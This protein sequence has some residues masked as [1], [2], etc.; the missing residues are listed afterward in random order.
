MLCCV[1]CACWMYC[2]YA[3][4]HTAAADMLTGVMC[5]GKDMYEFYMT[6]W[7][8]F[9]EL[10]TDMEREGIFVRVDFLGEV[11]HRALNDIQSSRDQFLRWAMEMCP[12]AKNMNVSRYL[13]L[14]QFSRI[15]ISCAELTLCCRIPVYS[16]AQKQQ[17]LLAPYRN[18]K[19]EVMLEAERKFSVDNEEGYI[20]VGETKAK[21]T[22]EFTLTGTG[23]YDR[24]RLKWPATALSSCC[25]CHLVVLI[26]CPCTVRSRN[27][28]SA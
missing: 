10:L 16:D 21:R 26:L 28:S 3:I 8:P 19:G 23:G 24:D 12:G 14:L 17:L 20:E 13:C 6:Y 27:S 7:R 1:E 11:R 25:Q 2:W 5:T 15:N 4:Q 18:A 22:R 9:G